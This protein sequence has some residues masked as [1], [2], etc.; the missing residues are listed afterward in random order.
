[1]SA[2]LYALLLFSAAQDLWFK[3]VEP[4]L[5]KDERTLYSSL[6]EDAR[7]AFRTGFWASKAI[8]ESDYFAR[9]EYIDNAFGSGQIGSG[10]N[11]DPGRIYFGLGPPTSIARLPSSR[12]F[13]PTEI[14]AYDHVPGLQTGSRVHFLFFRPRDLGQMK[15]YSPQIHT[16]RAL[17]INNAGTRSLFPV[18]DVITETDVRER[19]QIS[20]AEMD[21][22]E[23]AM[24]VA[25]GIKKS[26]NSEILYLASSPREM[27][28]RQRLGLA[29][30]RVSY[31]TERPKLEIKQ[32]ATPNKIPAIDLTFTGIARNAIAVEIR[33][34]ES[35]TNRLDYDSAKPYSYTQRVYLLPG[36]Y[37]V[38]VEVDG[39]RTGYIVEV[40]KLTPTDPLTSPHFPGADWAAIGR[41]YLLAQDRARASTCFARALAAGRSVDALVGSARLTANLDAA[42]ALLIEALA[43]Q[44]N[45]FEALVT[46][47]GLTAEFQDY[48][49]AASYY[50]RALAIRRVPVIEEALARLASQGR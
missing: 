12:V 41:Q 42:R 30:S 26:G 16:I 32:L 14:W 46:L 4:V 11:T 28:S 13:Y 44:P 33:D 47:G 8:G 6:T 25:R 1:M 5:S 27:L 49:L 38:L 9:V 48:P 21:V 24:G 22:L 39:F 31:R 23:A 50:E 17:I 29:R 36:E 34:L 10:A 20:P 37:T 45:H 40:V 7:D 35:F 3:R 15:L 19:M 2:A 43:I 18:N